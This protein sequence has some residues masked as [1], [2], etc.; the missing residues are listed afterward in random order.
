MR[1][2]RRAAGTAGF[3]SRFLVVATVLGFVAIREAQP[4]VAA[5]LP[6]FKGELVALDDTFR[7]DRLYID[8]EGADQVV[9]LDVGLAHA[10]SVNGRTFQPD[11]RGRATASTLVG[12]VTLPCVL[13]TA[14]ALAWPLRRW[15]H[16]ATR[17]LLL[18]P[19]LL[20]LCVLNAPFILWAALW[21]L[22]VQVADPHPFSPLLMWSDFLIGGGGFAL[23]LALG[24][25]V[26]S[27]SGPSSR[28]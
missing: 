9:R 23:A 1:H 19:A 8:R 26:G 10:L 5:L 13:L 12:N 11:P 18:G 22:V 2:A 6:L 28:T 4:V 20:L 14:I 17:A 15:R 21:G 27:L 16:L 3:V 7:V 24:A 25:C